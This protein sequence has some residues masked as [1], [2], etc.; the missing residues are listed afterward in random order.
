MLAVIV[1][2][3]EPIS[4]TMLLG[5]TA[6]RM[7]QATLCFHAQTTQGRCWRDCWWVGN[8]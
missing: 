3:E 8:T 5:S 1:W 2:T 7:P 6:G 4:Y